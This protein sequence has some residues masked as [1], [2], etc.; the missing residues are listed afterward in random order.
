MQTVF[1]Y[2]D[3]GTGSLLLQATIAGVLG[4]AMFLKNIK[5]RLMS[6][7]EA[8]NFDNTKLVKTLKQQYAVLYAKYAAFRTS[9]H[10]M[11]NLKTKWTSM[12]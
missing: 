2:L 10:F 12:F 9:V 8:R 6:F 11:K 4:F 7:W 1:L 3:P 5:Y